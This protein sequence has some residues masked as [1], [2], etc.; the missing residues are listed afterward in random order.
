MFMVSI[1][2]EMCT[3]CG[4]CA[5]GCPAHILDFDGTHASVS[6]DPCDCM[7]C[8]A[9]VTVCPSGACSVVEL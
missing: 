7:G 8:E 9:C 6:G 2:E 5:E 4:Q 1:D 3:G